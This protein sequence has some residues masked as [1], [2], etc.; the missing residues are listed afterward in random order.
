MSNNRIK[1]FSEK[2]ARVI[3][4]QSG[5]DCLIDALASL[6]DCEAAFAVLNRPDAAP[7]YLADTYP[8][9]TSKAAVQRY[10]TTTYQ[11][12][13]AH[14]AIREGLTTGVY[15]MADL[16][17]DNWR[18]TTADV[19]ADESE[20]INFRTPGWPQGLQEVSV[21]VGLEDGIVGEVSLARTAI[22]GGVPDA[23][24]EH[25]RDVLPL[26]RSAFLK[27]A[28]FALENRKTD[29]LAGEALEQFGADL[30]SPREQEVVQLILKGHSSLSISLVLDIA[31][32]TV[33][34]HRRN[35]YAKLGVSTQQQ[36]FH[37]YLEWH[38]ALN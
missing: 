25:L 37:A 10:V 2:L 16:A 15:R 34:S 33:K 31:L 21:L 19:I 24:L 12:N 18:A 11:I 30:F 4:G 17:P 8:D 3:D 38:S 28:P 32:P 6:Y 13:P 9:V 1:K 26:V 35:A 14:N 36:L 27:L 20:E 23:D 7:I 29:H 5:A 22:A